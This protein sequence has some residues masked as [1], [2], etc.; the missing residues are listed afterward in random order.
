MRSRNN[1][2]TAHT[3]KEILSELE[4]LV[5]EVQALIADSATEHSVE[6]VEALRQRFADAQ[7]RLAATYE[8]AKTKVVEGAKATDATIREN[9]YQSIAIGVGVG[10]L[11]GMLLGRRGN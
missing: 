5:G 7:E 6:A 4:T 8:T 2:K 1:L 10:L 3:P 11:L 9:P